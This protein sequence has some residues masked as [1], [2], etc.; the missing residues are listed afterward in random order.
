MDVGGSLGMDGI[1][2]GIGWGSAMLG[3][4]FAIYLHSSPLTDLQ[5]PSFTQE[6]LCLAI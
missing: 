1:G 4:P 2:I 6:Y 3:A 5:Q